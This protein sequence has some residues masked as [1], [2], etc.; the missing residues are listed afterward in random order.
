MLRTVQKLSAWIVAVSILA[1]GAGGVVA[2]AEPIRNPI[3]LQFA[4]IRSA[5][6]SL[7]TVSTIS[8]VSTPENGDYIQFEVQ[9]STVGISTSTTVSV[10]TE[11]LSDAPSATIDTDYTFPTIPVGGTKILA[12]NSSG[13]FNIRLPIVDDNILEPDEGVRIAIYNGMEADVLLASTT[14][15]IQDDERHSDALR[16]NT[17]LGISS[18]ASLMNA[19]Q[20]AVISND[21]YATDLENERDD[22]GR[23][24]WQTRFKNDYGSTGYGW[25]RVETYNNASGTAIDTQ[26]VTMRNDSAFVI[27]FRGTQQMAADALTDALAITKRVP[28]TSPGVYVHVGFWDALDPVYSA[29]VN[30]LKASRGDRTVWITGHSLGGA[31]AQ[32]MAYRIKMSSDP[33]VRNSVVRVVTFG[34]PQTGQTAFNNPSNSN[35]FLAK[36]GAGNMQRWVNLQDP[37][38]QVPGLTVPGWVHNST[39]TLMREDSR[40]NLQVRAG[41]P[42]PRAGATGVSF[43]DHSLD[44]YM[45][46]LVELNTR[47]TNLTLEQFESYAPLPK[48]APELP[49]TD[50]EDPAFIEEIKTLGIGV[51]IGLV[52]IIG[53]VIGL[54]ILLL[55][56]L[57]LSLDFVWNEIAG[58]IEEAY[59][60][61]AAEVAELMNTLGAS[62]T[63]IARALRNVFSITASEIVNLLSGIGIT[64]AEIAT[65]L[66]SALSMSYEAIASLFKTLGQAAADVVAAFK[67]AFSSLNFSSVAAFLDSAGYALKI[68]AE[69]IYDAFVVTVNAL[70]LALKNL[71]KAALDV[72]RALLEGIAATVSQVASALKTVFLA[73]VDLAASILKSIG[74]VF[75]DIVDVL[76]S[77]FFAT[78]SVIATALKSI[79]ALASQIATLLVDVLGAAINAVASALQAA[80]GAI[81]DTI[82][83][84]LKTAFEATANAVAAALKY[85]GGAINDVAS[86][87]KAAFNWVSWVGGKYLASALEFAFGSVFNAIAGAVKTVLNLGATAVAS[88]IKYIG[89]TLSEVAYAIKSAFSWVAEQATELAEALESVFGA[90]YDSIASAIKTVLGLASSA[91][92]NVIRVIGATWSEVASAIKS[93]FTATINTVASVLNGLGASF[94]SIATAVKTAF[95]ATASAVASAIKAIGASISQAASALKSAFGTVYNTIASALKTAY[96]ASISAITSALKA[97]GAGVSAV[98]NA[99]KA[100]TFGIVA[101]ANAIWDAFTIGFDAF[102][103]LLEAIGASAAQAFDIVWD[104]FFG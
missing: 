13:R 48:P 1:L 54:S 22:F 46:R 66:K 25:N 37:V 96:S 29:I 19:Y 26:A 28:G 88:I 45:D 41:A 76:S 9:W 94:D 63:E 56:Q 12:A 2:H 27:A 18:E 68:I 5:V 72:A 33:G 51:G 52:A 98:A 73:T 93:A 65:A 86:A 102:I 74:V 17:P 38:P 101:I 97:L 35:S 20:L 10:L 69:A 89:G 32:L 42:M 4:P 83:S 8:P 55:S 58:V 50:T 91:V 60:A 64:L 100:A 30:E 47:R 99:L 43:G 71:G 62:A 90:V 24:Q 85:I 31:L 77:V 34:A 21:I 49:D 87:L 92:A 103:D 80:F 6:S 44:L 81:Y 67:T 23:L 84:A 7:P 57:M 79:G 59:N 53:I 104:F 75:A 15:T 36:V 70:A 78:L 3:D 40:G 95:S 14:I 82:A 61:T 16:G 39:T 11:S